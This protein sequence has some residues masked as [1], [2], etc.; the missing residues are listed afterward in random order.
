[1]TAGQAGLFESA[2][3]G[4]TRPLADRMRPR[5]LDDLVGQAH[6]FGPGKPLRVAVEAGPRPLD[7]LLG[8]ARHREDDPWDGWSPPTRTRASS[9]SRRCCPG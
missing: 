6:L 4:A 3:A 5:T 1:M 8:A 9:R 7:D 2:A